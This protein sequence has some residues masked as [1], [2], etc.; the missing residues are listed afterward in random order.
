[1][2]LQL[3]SKIDS[4]VRNCNKHIL[5]KNV[6]TNQTR[7]CTMYVHPSQIY[8]KITL[9]EISTTTYF[10]THILIK[11]INKT[12]IIRKLKYKKQQ[13]KFKELLIQFFKLYSKF[14]AVITN[15]SSIQGTDQHQ[16]RDYNLC[17]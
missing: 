9:S 7:P 6:G 5:N 1:M 3:F 16:N 10:N 4:S 2:R 12:S 11:A 17:Y 8:L 14:L 15:N 13:T